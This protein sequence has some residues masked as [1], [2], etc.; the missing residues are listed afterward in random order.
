[1][2][3]WTGLAIGIIIGAVTGFAIPMLLIK[4]GFWAIGSLI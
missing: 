1:M 2:G 3:F 4:F